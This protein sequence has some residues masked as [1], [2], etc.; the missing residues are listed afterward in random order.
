[1][2]NQFGDDR[3]PLAVCSRKSVRIRERRLHYDIAGNKID[4]LPYCL[5]MSDVDLPV[6]VGAD[7]LN[8]PNTSKIRTGVQPHQRLPHISA[9]RS[10][11]LGMGESARRLS[12]YY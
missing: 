8:H 2:R 11:S 5:R 10:I 6:E 4:P 12:R 9:T 1:L 3:D 7:L